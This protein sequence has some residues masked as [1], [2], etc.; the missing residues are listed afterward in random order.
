MKYLFIILLVLMG[1][2]LKA[3]TPDSVY[4][5]NIYSARLYLKGNPLAYPIITLNGNERMELVFD[6]L[7][8]DVKSY[9]YTYQ[10]CNADWTPVQISTF[11]YIRGLRKTRLPTIIILPSP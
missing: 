11:D 4:M 6:D 5:P 3:Q 7:D 10:L 2:A 9:Y 1:T 8:A